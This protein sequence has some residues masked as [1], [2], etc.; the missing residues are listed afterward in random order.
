MSKSSTRESHARENSSLSA[1][2]SADKNAP[3]DPPVHPFN[4]TEDVDPRFE[5][6]DD[7]HEAMDALIEQGE[8]EVMPERLL[9]G[10]FKFLFEAGKLN[11]IE[12]VKAAYARVLGDDDLGISPEF[13]Y[14]I[15]LN[16]FR[17]SDPFGLIARDFAGKQ[18]DML[19]GERKLYRENMKQLQK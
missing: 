19:E 18:M 8:K 9:N 16:L 1:S 11:T 17:S 13:I 5:L 2:S 6:T 4:D 12:D 10:H 14:E 7:L 3:P 15:T